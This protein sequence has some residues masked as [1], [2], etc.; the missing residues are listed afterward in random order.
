MKKLGTIIKDEKPLLTLHLDQ[1]SQLILKSYSKSYHGYLCFSV[2]LSD[3]IGYFESKITLA[4]LLSIA[5]GS[6]FLFDQD[7]KINR[8]PLEKVINS[9]TFIDYYFNQIPENYKK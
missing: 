7:Q 2:N 9:L 8:I 1:E 3:L 4:D 6:F 5:D